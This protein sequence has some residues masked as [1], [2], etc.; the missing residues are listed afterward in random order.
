VRGAARLLPAA[1]D[2]Q[3][4]AL[5][6]VEA[7]VLRCLGDE[8][9][10]VE[11][12]QRATANHRL[13]PVVAARLFVADEV[14]ASARWTD[15]HRP[16]AGAIAAWPRLAASMTQSQRRAALDLL[17]R[18]RPADWLRPRIEAA[19][20]ALLAVDDPRGAAVARVEWLIE[21][22]HH[23]RWRSRL[24]ALLADPEGAEVAATSPRLHDALFVRAERVARAGRRTEGRG[25]VRFAIQ[26]G[27]LDAADERAMDEWLGALVDL[28]SA[29]REDRGR[30]RLEAVARGGGRAAVEAAWSLIGDARREDRD[31]EALDRIGRLNQRRVG[32][33]TAELLDACIILAGHL[34]DLEVQRS[35][36]DLRTLRAATPDELATL[37]VD[38]VVD[39]LAVRDVRDARQLLDAWADAPWYRSLPDPERARLT[40]WSGRVAWESGA[41]DE[42]VAAWRE[43]RDRIPLSY[44][45]V[46]ADAWLERAGE[47]PRLRALLREAFAPDGGAAAL[48]RHALA[49]LELLQLGFDDL[50]R[51]ELAW[52][53]QLLGDGTPVAGAAAAAWMGS[54]GERG[55]AIWTIGRQAEPDRW[56]R[57][58]VVDVPAAGWRAGWPLEQLRPLRAASYASGQPTSRLLAFARRESAFATTAVSGAGARGLMQLLPETARIQ[59]RDVADIERVTRRD[60]DDPW[61]NAR[62]GAQMLVAMS[63]RYG[64]C[65]ELMAAAYSAGPGRADDWI[66]RTPW[67]YNDVWTERIPY[68]VVRD[69]AREVVVS[70]AIYAALLDE[71]VR[72]PLCVLPGAP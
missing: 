27:W 32:V 56:T 15:P 38:V 50:A 35:C 26:Q 42:A 45:G 48:D 17:A 11:A 1:T 53:S 24:D 21:H 28:G 10:A 65:V 40:Y 13:R 22:P 69:Y 52:Q 9:A 55:A 66:E 67:G 8:T 19:R 49:G 37:A 57:D 63:A 25:L 31:R 41:G 20:H 23:A 18:A 43:V 60:L 34:G 61:I 4:G 16:G 14:A 71:P 54:R 2:R 44:E 70:E 39:H 68:P 47:A 6:F 29:R 51:T 33:R 3:R 59:A 46:L 58:E 62:L 5:A 7:E 12:W 64:G 72:S 36:F 30:D